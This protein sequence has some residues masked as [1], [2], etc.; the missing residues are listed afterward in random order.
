M[1]ICEQRSTDQRED[2]RIAAAALSRAD[3]N[4]GLAVR[5]RILAPVRRVEAN[6]EKGR[7]R[8]E[9]QCQREAADGHRD[10]ERGRRREPDQEARVEVGRG[11]PEPDHEH[12]GRDRGS[13]HEERP[14]E[15]RGRAHK[16]EQA[17]DDKRGPRS[18]EHRRQESKR[19]ARPEDVAGAT[20]GADHRGTDVNIRERTE[21]DGGRPACQ[22]GARRP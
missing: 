21:H 9:R 22:P 5:Q 2:A 17:E 7:S 8:D 11:E 12:P 19:E 18:A 3:E 16:R 4:G 1:R 20:R 6:H 10:G 13:R 14:T 15:D